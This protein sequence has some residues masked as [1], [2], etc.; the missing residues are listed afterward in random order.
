MDV[1]FL[2]VQSNVCGACLDQE[3]L[4]LLEMLVP[5]NFTSGWNL[6]GAKHKMF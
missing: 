2:V 1:I 3:D 6:L 5:R 4:V